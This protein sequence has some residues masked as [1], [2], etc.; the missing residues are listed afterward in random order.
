MTLLQAVAAAQAPMTLADLEDAD[1][2]MAMPAWKQIRRLH[3]AAVKLGL[4]Q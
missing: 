4:E 1:A 2:V 3:I